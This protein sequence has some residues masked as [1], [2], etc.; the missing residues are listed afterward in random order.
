M[1]WYNGGS[2]DGNF[3]TGFISGL[4]SGAI[5]GFVQGG[6]ISS[7][8]AIDQGRNPITGNALDGIGFRYIGE[9]EM[10]AIDRDGV[11][12]GVDA[13]GKPKSVH[14][15]N[16]FYDDAQSAQ[17]KLALPSKP[18]FRVTFKND[19]IQVIHEGMVKPNYGQYDGGYE[20]HVF[21]GNWPL[22]SPIRIDQL[23]VNISIPKN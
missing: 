22:V 21:P 6:I 1:S 23:K 2:F 12:P 15:S 17:S 16:E 7:A 4:K 11:I 8:Q 18:S 3:G 14:Y 10:Q 9:G 19:Q 20:F 5:N 13:K